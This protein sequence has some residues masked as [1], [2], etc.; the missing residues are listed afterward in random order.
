MAKVIEL[1][2][3][4]N[5]DKQSIKLMKISDEIDAVILNHICDKDIEPKDIAGILAHRLG[6]LMKNIS[7]TQ[8]QLLWDVCKKILEQQADLDK[9]D[10][11]L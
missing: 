11:C 10:K 1:K 5:R 7:P 8:R 4:N 6:T 3:K 2:P 9:P